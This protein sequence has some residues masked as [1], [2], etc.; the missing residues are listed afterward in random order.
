MT[1]SAI[2][3]MDAWLKNGTLMCSGPDKLLLAWGQRHWEYVLDS[4]STNPFFYFPYFFLEEKVPWFW[5]EY[6]A[7]VSVQDLLKKVVSHLSADTNAERHFWKNPYFSVF[8]RTFSDLQAKI[9]AKELAKAVPYVFEFSEYTMSQKML[10]R[11][12]A[13]LLR[14][15]VNN[16]VYAYGFWG[17]EQGLLGAT[18]ELLF[19]IDDSRIIKTMACAGTIAIAADEKM[20]DAN[21]AFMQDPKEVYEHKIVVQGIKKSLSLYGTVR[22]GNMQL[23]KLPVLSHLMTPIDVHLNR[24]VDFE[25]IVHALHPTPALGAFPRKEGMQWLKEY[26]NLIDRRRFGAPAGYV[27]PMQNKGVCY[28]AIRNVQWDKDSMCIGAG[29]GVVASS[30]CQKE[31]NEINLKLGAIKGMLAL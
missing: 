19:T 10:L 29:C 30:S 5:Q 18:P 15:T 23:L 6:T 2:L 27:F 31:W 24:Q 14:Y 17:E 25:Q 26:Q 3:D 1:A 21:P 22:I 9:Q 28:V 20:G 8:T 13:A 12:L 16:P 4:K 7:E 11:S